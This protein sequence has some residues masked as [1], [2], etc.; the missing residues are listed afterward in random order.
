MEPVIVLKKCDTC[1][2]EKPMAAFQQVRNGIGYYRSCTDCWRKTSSTWWMGK[3]LKRVN[4][5]NTSCQY[6]CFRRISMEY[7]IRIAFL[8]MRLRLILDIV[9]RRV[10]MVE[11]LRKL[12]LLNY[13]MKSPVLVKSNVKKRRVDMNTIM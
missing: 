10:L 7:P 2:M 8:V 11:L 1:Q 6:G 9:E 3:E 5:A 12:L 13:W 4:D